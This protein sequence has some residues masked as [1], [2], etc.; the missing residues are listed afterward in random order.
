MYDIFYESKQI[1]FLYQLEATFK[2]QIVILGTKNYIATGISG[3][4][5]YFEH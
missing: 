1:S 5:I 3:N 2:E 4:P